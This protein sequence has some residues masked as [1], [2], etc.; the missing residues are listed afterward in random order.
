M[1]LLKKKKI[2]VEGRRWPW[3][4]PFSMRMLSPL[5]TWVGLHRHWPYT[6]MVALHLRIVLSKSINGRPL[7]QMLRLSST[8]GLDTYF[9]SQVFFFRPSPSRLSPGRNTVFVSVERIVQDLASFPLWGI[10]RE[11]GPLRSPSCPCAIATTRKQKTKPKNNQQNKTTTNRENTVVMDIGALVKLQQLVCRWIRSCKKQTRTQNITGKSAKK[12]QN[13]NQ[14]QRRGNPGSSQPGSRRY[15]TSQDK[16]FV[17]IA[18]LHPLMGR[19]RLVLVQKARSRLS[20]QVAAALTS[21][22][23]DHHLTASNFSHTP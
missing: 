10:K 7:R 12:V 18:R 23:R 11:H 16:L 22:N 9:T 6:I 20:T 13:N 15:F 17:V 8:G 3:L 21:H 4:E 2:A 1:P 19:Y 5:L 14:V